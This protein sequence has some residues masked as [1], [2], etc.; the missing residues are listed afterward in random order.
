MRFRFGHSYKFHRIHLT[1]PLSHSLQHMDH[2]F[3]RVSLE[4]EDHQFAL[5]LWY[6]WKGRNNK[7]FS[8]LDID[9]RDTLR[10]AETETLLWAEAQISLTKGFD[11]TRV[12]VEAISPSIL[13]RWCLRLD[14]GKIMKSF[15]DKG[16]IAHWKVL[17]V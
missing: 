9:P 10:L 8:N 7:V 17:K 6:M 3:W 15:R 16:D 13:G 12:P 2:L 14:H 4:L 11:Q 1:F 5:I